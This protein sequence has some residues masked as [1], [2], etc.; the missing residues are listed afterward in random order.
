MKADSRSRFVKKRRPPSPS[1]ATAL[2]LSLFCAS[3]H[4]ETIVWDF[5]GDGSGT[6]GDTTGTIFF[7]STVDPLANDTAFAFGTTAGE[8]NPINYDVGTGIGGEHNNRAAGNSYFL[9]SDFN[10]I[11]EGGNANNP[12]K[13]GDGR[14]GALRSDLFVIDETSSFSF[15]IGGGAGNA[16][17]A[18]D[19]DNALVLRNASDDSAILSY[20]PANGHIYRTGNNSQP[21]DGLQEWSNT[22]LTGAGVSGSTEV[23]LT[24]ED[25]NGGGWGHIQLDDVTVENAQFINGSPRINS[26]TATPNNLPAAGNVTLEWEVEDAESISIDQGVGDV[27]GMTRASCPSRSASKSAV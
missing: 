7:R 26:F 23:Y 6:L 22:D 14:R 9:R 10:N 8:T 2:I 25:N 15:Y 27:T 19:S 12:G 21:N 4:A 11:P 5:E 3:P 24:V 1:L 17:G 18:E 20:T 16:S 13:H